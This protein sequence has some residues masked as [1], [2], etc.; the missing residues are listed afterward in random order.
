MSVTLPA[1]NISGIKDQ[2]I[3][4]QLTHPKCVGAGMVNLD[5]QIVRSVSIH[6]PDPRSSRLGEIH[7]TGRRIFALQVG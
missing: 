6:Q 2:Q 5:D 1:S 4:D 7:I 3:V